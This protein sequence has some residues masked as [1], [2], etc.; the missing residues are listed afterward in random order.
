M[1]S[2]YTAS[3]CRC[4]G[5]GLD[6]FIDISAVVLASETCDSVL[7]IVAQEY[8]IKYCL[9]PP[10]TNQ[11]QYRLES[12]TEFHTTLYRHF[13]VLYCCILYGNL[14]VFLL[15]GRNYYII[16]NMP[17]GERSIPPRIFKITTAR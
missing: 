8:K 1:I 15:R 17:F 11:E 13:V 6:D 2:L 10:T 9:P 7:S 16:D 5:S 4:A 12:D 3:R 14:C